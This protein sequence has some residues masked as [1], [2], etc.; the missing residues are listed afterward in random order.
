M[1]DRFLIAPFDT[2]SG[3]QN[4][5]KPWLIPN[6]AFAGLTDMYQFRERVR[7]RFGTRWLENNPFGT[8]LRFNVGVLGGGGS[9]AGN[10]RTIAVDPTLPLSRGQGFTVTNA[11]GD[12]IFFTIN[13]TL[14]GPQQ[15]L[16]SDGLAA[17]AT[18]DIGTGAFNITGTGFPAGRDVFFYPA[19]PVMGLRTYEQSSINNE[20]TIAFDTKYAYRYIAGDGWDRLAAVGGGEPA[21]A[22]V[23][24]GSN[25]EFFYSYTYS[26]SNVN[27]KDLY[28]T[29]FNESEPM[30]RL[31][32]NQWF[33]FNPLCEPAPSAVRINSARIIVPFKNR[34]LMFNTWEGAAFPGTNY[35]S[36]VAWS[37]A[38]DPTAVDAFRRIPGQGG[39]LDAT[40]SEAIVSIE[41]VKDRLIVGFDRSHW[42]LVYT[43]NQVQPFTWQKINTELGVESTFSIVPFDRVVLGIGYQGIHACTGASVDRVDSKI[44]DEVFKIHNLDDGVFRVYGIRDYYLECVY[45]TFPSDVPNAAFPFPS[46]ILVYNYKANTWAFFNDSITCFGYF[47]N[48][49]GITWDSKT[50]TWDSSVSWDSGLLLGLFREVIAGNQQGYTFICDSSKTANDPN[51]QITDITT[52]PATRLTIINHNLRNEDYIYIQDCTYSDF[53]D[54]LNDQIF[55]VI[56]VIDENTID[57]GPIAPFTG[58]YTGGGIA[59]RVAKPD[60]RTKEFNFY[61]EQGRNAYISKVDFMVDKTAHGEI[62][63]DFYVSTS[64]TPFLQESAQNGTLVG[65]GTL[66]TFAYT[67]ANGAITPYNYEETA[68]RVWHP[69]YF[70]A[71]GEV[72]QL[73]LTM[74]DEQMRDTNIRNC[75]LQ[76]HAM[77]IT[78]IPTSYRLQ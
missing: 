24:S 50:V 20:Q 36:R 31:S 71:E 6:Q 43:Q 42:E 21:T 73:Q 78:A 66:E 27:I 25:S 52:T 17:V 72:V 41:F 75:D 65:T 53:S 1:A 68:S 67:A 19:L 5:V 58:T 70:Q 49:T 51:L 13:S 47:Q 61:A 12:T 22:A 76:L 63:V 28:V 3:L 32:G 35:Q 77:C 23:W 16:R 74:N 57:I 14:A 45:W 60:I 48:Q 18:F 8:R 2:S 37:A 29:N 40:T 46:R 9:L 11:A 56:N 62:Q 15:M 39:A 55:Q 69:V 4:N 10:V 7:K 34:L 33:N 64:Y 44:P 54:G 38:G 26:G 30:R 59:A